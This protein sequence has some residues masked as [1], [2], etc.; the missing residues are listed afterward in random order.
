MLDEISRSAGRTTAELTRR[1]VARGLL[2]VP[3]VEAL[4]RLAELRRELADAGSPL[5]EV[6]WA[7]AEQILAS[8]MEKRATVGEVR[9]WLEATGS[10]PTHLIPAELFVWP[11]EDE[12]GPVATELHA[13]LVSH[14]A[15]L[16]ADGTIDPDRLLAGD[17]DA[18][19]SYRQIQLDWLHTPLPDGQEPAHAIAD[20][21]ADEFL[22]EWEEAEADAL[23]LLEE[24]LAE[25]PARTCP[26]DE[27]RAACERI[28]D[29][30]ATDE[31][32]AQVVRVAGGL[33]GPEL[34]GDDRELWLSLA[35][36]VVTQQDAPPE[37]ALDVDSLVAWSMLEHP[38]WIA[39][40]VTLARGGP[41]RPADA[42]SLAEAATTFEFEAGD[43]EAEEEEEVDDEEVDDDPWSEEDREVGKEQLQLGF[44][45]V[46]RLWQLLG[47]VDGTERL[48][49]LGWWGLP[50]ALRRAWQPVEPS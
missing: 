45:T 21:D 23:E 43:D 42:G 16:V 50:E 11:D 1:D 34:P 18:L 12:R 15:A 24:L 8:I 48:T 47:A 36:G 40:V 31:P 44:T 19:A 37:S 4:E 27:L 41:G 20:E 17:R 25:L 28:R 26:E 29:R 3:A 30:L 39:A 9:Q 6:F 46:V 32:L 10:E 49:D 38:D 2:T 7:S 5:S 33:A 35:A 13:Q 22:A 14:L